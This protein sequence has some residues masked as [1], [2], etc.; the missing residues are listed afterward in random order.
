MRLVGAELKSVGFAEHRMPDKEDP[1]QGT[2][3]SAR[4]T[5]GKSPKPAT[6]FRGLVDLDRRKAL[7]EAIVSKDDPWFAGAFVNRMWGELMGQ[8]FYQPIDDLG[9]EKEAFMPEVLA[10]VAG[11]F[12]GSDYDIKGLFRTLVN[13][14]TYQRQI[15][16]GESPDQHLLVAA[17]NTGRLT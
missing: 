15:R 16:P 17:H 10:R 2:A 3:M 1:K 13:S 7:A 6:T 8:A 11:S 4:F 14:D 5:D 12:R 9:P